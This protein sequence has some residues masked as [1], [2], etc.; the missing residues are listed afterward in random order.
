M[1]AN[2]YQK[3]AA[4]TLIDHPDFALSDWDIMVVWSALGLA[5]EAGEVA[6]LVKKGILHQHGLDRVKLEN[7]LGDV[8]WYVAALCSKLD[9]DMGQVMQANVDK[10][11]VRYPAGYSAADSQ[12]RVDAT[13]GGGSAN[14]EPGAVPDNL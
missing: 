10:L 11:L 6:N 13:A 9:I 7:E 5:G 3:L 2:E 12:R 1:D 14:E 8:L 4:R